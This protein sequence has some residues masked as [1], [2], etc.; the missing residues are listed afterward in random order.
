MSFEEVYEEKLDLISRLLETLMVISYLPYKFEV[1]K[2]LEHT[3][4]EIER[5]KSMLSDYDD[6]EYV[7]SIIKDLTELEEDF[8]NGYAPYKKALDVALKIKSIIL[9]NALKDLLR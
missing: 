1:Y 5:L 9:N 6:Y 2:N 4:Y 7:E 8:L 3:I